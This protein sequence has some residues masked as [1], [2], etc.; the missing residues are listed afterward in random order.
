MSMCSWCNNQSY[1]RANMQDLFSEVDEGLQYCQSFKA[2]L[3]M[4][5]MG[6]T[7]PPWVNEEKSVT[8]RD[9][10]TATARKFPNKQLFM[11]YSKQPMFG[12]EPLGIGQMIA[13]PFKQSTLEM[14][15]EDY[16]NEG[17]HY[18]DLRHRDIKG[19]LPLIKACIRW[20]DSD[21]ML[22]VVPFMIIEV[23]P[24]MKEKYSTDEEV[25]RCVKALV[26]ALP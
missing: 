8:R 20:K 1:C 22:T 6:R 5:S 13:D 4:I 23:F 24:G 14:G 15:S 17:F 12:G 16:D 11:A 10:S 26:E 3:P 21:Q 25:V 7:S 18:L 2:T 19:T 9:W